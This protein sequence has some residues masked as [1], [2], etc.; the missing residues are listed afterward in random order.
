MKKSKYYYMVE[1]KEKSGK[2]IDYNVCEN[3]KDAKHY[4][5]LMDKN[6]KTK[7]LKNESEA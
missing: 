4:K 7:I 3:L 5:K 1:V 6:F 2:F